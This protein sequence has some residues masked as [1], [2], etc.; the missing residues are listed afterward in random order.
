MELTSRL[1]VENIRVTKKSRHAM[2]TKPKI[3]AVLHC[4]KSP[5]ANVFTFSKALSTNVFFV[6]SLTENT[7]AIIDKRCKSTNKL[8]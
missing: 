3:S 4:A 5:R 6:I 7:E 8:N 1:N 2:P